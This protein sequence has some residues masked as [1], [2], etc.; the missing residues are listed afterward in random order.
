VPNAPYD[1]VFTEADGG[2]GRFILILTSGCTASYTSSAC[3]SVQTPET[4]HSTSK[5][6][7]VWQTQISNKNVEN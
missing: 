4:S 3:K 6:V 5:K 1:G 2:Q 7:Q